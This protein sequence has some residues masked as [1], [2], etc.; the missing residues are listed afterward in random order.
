MSQYTEAG[1]AQCM[2]L[3]SALSL[4]TV[5]DLS[6]IHPARPRDTAATGQAAA[7]TAFP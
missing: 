5:A 7:F 2:R 1:S 6:A 3:L 4:W